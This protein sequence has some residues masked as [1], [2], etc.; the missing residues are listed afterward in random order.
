MCLYFFYCISFR[1]VLPV[2]R[3][4]FDLLW[5]TLYL[6]AIPVYICVMCCMCVYYKSSCGR[7]WPVVMR[8]FFLAAIAI[9]RQVTPTHSG[10]NV[11]GNYH[12]CD[13]THDDDDTCCRR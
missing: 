1:Y 9:H 11:D 10:E 2:N 13:S 8:I 5:H 7:R 4:N 6:A 3:M 12:R